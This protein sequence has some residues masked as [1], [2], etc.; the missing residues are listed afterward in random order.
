MKSSLSPSTVEKVNH[1][2]IRSNFPDLTP[3]TLLESFKAEGIRS[4][5][6]LA[7]RLTKA[8]RDPE[9][10]PQR[11]NYEDLFSQPT[12]REVLETIE[13]QVPKVPFVVDGAIH[14]PEDIVRYNG[15]ELGFIPQKGGTELL[16]LKDKSVWAPFLRT[17]LLSRA[18]SAALMPQGIP[19]VA[20]SVG[21]PLDATMLNLTIEGL[22]MGPFGPP[23]PPPLRPEVWL[24]TDI[25]YAGSGLVLYSGESRRNLLEVGD[26]P[27]VSDFN[28]KFS[29]V[30]RTSGLSMGFE[31]IHFQGSF[32]WLG[33]SDTGWYD[34]TH[35]GWNDRISSVIN[36]G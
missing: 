8:L 11:I 20:Q 24:F 3:E 26:W 14:D 22:P 33:P 25:A 18:V 16:V 31:H 34:L 13:H 28:D 36:S 19:S 32:L 35:P 21:N 29:S 6:D 23:V 10:L 9:G 1:I 30:Y 17:A 27:W 12:P 15:Q 4:L 7:Q 2:I 5:E